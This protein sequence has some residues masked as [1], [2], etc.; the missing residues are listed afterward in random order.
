MTSTETQELKD[1]LQRVRELADKEPELTMIRSESYKN[2]Y[3]DGYER[4][5]RLIRLALT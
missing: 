1:K 2:A 5:M 3:C 4:A